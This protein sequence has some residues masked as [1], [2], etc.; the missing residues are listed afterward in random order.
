MLGG[1]FEEETKLFFDIG[2]SPARPDRAPQPDDPFAERYPGVSPSRA[3]SSRRRVTL[4]LT[5]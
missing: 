5:L 3:R 4:C 1:H 2:V